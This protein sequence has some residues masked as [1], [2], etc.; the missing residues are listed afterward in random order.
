MA[1]SVTI[2]VAAGVIFACAG[3]ALAVVVHD[4]DPSQEDKSRTRKHPTPKDDPAQEVEP[5]EDLLPTYAESCEALPNPRLIGHDLGELF[6]E[7]GAPK[8]GCGGNA[9][10]VQGTGAWMAAGI[11]DGQL[12]SVAISAP[13]REAVILYGEAAEFAWTAGQQE[14]LVAAEAAQPAEG[15]VD[16]VEVISGTY[17]FAR[18]SPSLTQGRENI[19]WCTEATGR[20]RPFVRLAPPLLLLWRELLQEEAGWS[21]PTADPSAEPGD[22]I[23]FI[24]YPAG[25]LTATGACLTDSDC[26]LRVGTDRWP[27]EGSGFVSLPELV[28]FMPQPVG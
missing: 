9:I 2:P 18:S 27:G 22:Q 15:E 20:A 17:G 24:S 13:G 4:G 23:A 3:L 25:E 7:E 10:H 28:P 6:E 26:H 1:F 8:A 21:W 19:R 5:E 14:T 16:L 11:C 12:R